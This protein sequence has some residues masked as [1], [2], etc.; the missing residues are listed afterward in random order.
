M[1]LEDT[2]GAACDCNFDFNPLLFI[3]FE[4]LNCYEKRHRHCKF[5]HNIDHILIKLTG[6]DR[7]W[8]DLLVLERSE[9]PD[10]P[11]ATTATCLLILTLFC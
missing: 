9:P 2:P 4:R 10:S 3:A 1:S 8:K 6:V 7:P 11:K 5:I